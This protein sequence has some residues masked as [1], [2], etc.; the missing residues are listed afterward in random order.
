[1]KLKSLKPF[2][3]SGIEG[4]FRVVAIIYFSY[5]GFD[6]IVT[7]TEEMKNPETS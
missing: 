2:F 3:P 1:M 6:N 7:T 4:V 5:V